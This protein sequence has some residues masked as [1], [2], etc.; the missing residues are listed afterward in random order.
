[1]RPFLVSAFSLAFPSGAFLEW[2]HRRKLLGT[3]CELAL[4]PWW[5]R[6]KLARAL[7]SLRGSKTRRAGLLAAMNFSLQHLALLSTSRVSRGTSRR[8]EDGQ[9]N[10]EFPIIMN[11]PI[12]SATKHIF[13]RFM[14]IRGCFLIET[15]CH[16][17]HRG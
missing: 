16:S 5:R 6:L 9:P 1:M 12:G 14:V 11:A 2:S 17:Y 10:R 15:S 4:Q 3:S 13:V 7:S 8:T